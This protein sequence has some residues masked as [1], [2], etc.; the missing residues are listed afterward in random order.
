METACNNKEGRCKFLQIATGV[1]NT[2]QQVEREVY[3]CRKG[4]L[5]TREEKDLPSSCNGREVGK[6]IHHENIEKT[7]CLQKV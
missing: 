3:T 2:N 1:T 7:K 4:Y 5:H 6:V